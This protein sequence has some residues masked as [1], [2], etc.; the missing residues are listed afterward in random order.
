MNKTKHAVAI[1]LFASTQNGAKHYTK[2]S[3]R[4]ILILLAKYHNIN[5]QRRW[6]FACLADMERLGYIRRKTRYHREPDGT[7]TQISSMVTFTL[8]GVKYLV[9]KRITGALALLKRMMR[10]LAGGDARWPQ[11]K[12][13]TPQRT[14]EEVKTN[15]ARFTKLLAALD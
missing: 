15:K 8:P 6:L 3:V 1:A 14:P 5:V 7:F 4:K 9:Q 11:E 13:L 12:E 2:A 10:W